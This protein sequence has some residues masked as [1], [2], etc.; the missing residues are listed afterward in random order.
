M[1]KLFTFLMTMVIAMVAANAADIK[2]TAVIGEEATSI[3]ALEGKT[4]AIINKAEGKALYG[5]NAQNLAYDVY[6]NAFVNT[7]SGYKWKLVSLADDAD[8]SVRSYYRIQLVTPTGADYNCWGMGGVLNSQPAGQDVSFILGIS[9]KNGQDIKNGAVYDVQYVEGEG[10]S[11]KNI[12]TG[13]YQGANTLPAKAA[14]PTYFSFVEEVSFNYIAAVKELLAEGEA[15]KANVA[16]EEAKE[17]YDAAIA[18]IDPDAL[19]GD[20]L[21]EAQAI[22]AAIIALAKHQNAGADLTR[23][24]ANP[25]FEAGNTDGWVNNGFAIAP[26]TDFPL[27]AGVKYAEKWTQA[28]G[29]VGDAKITQEITGLPNGIYE[30]SAAMRLIAQNEGD[31][32]KAGLFL[33]ANDEKVAV[34]AT[35]VIKA[36]IEVTDGVLVIGAEI[37]DAQGNWANIDNF[38]LT[39]EGAPATEEEMAPIVAEKAIAEALGVDVSAY[40]NQ[41]IAAAAVESVVNALKVAEYKQVNADYTQNAASLIPDFAEWEGGMVSNKGQHWDG[42]ATSTYY[43]QTGAQWGQSSW[44]NNKKTTVNLPKGKY[45][46]YAAGRASA[47]TDCIAYIKVNDE[48]RVF[49]SKGDVGFGIATDGVA[50]FDPATAAFANGNIGRGFEYRYIAFEVT[51][52]EGEDIALEIGGKATAAH[53]WMSVT[54]PILLTTADNATITKQVLAADIAIAQ[55]VVDAKAGVGDDLFMI[56]TEAFDTFEAAVNAAKDVNDNA[57]A[58]TEDIN[59]AIADLAAATEAYNSTPV[60]TPDPK[61]LYTFQL[62]LDAETPLYMNLSEGVK[63]QEEATPLSFVAAA[64]AGQYYLDARG[65]LS[66]GRDGGNTW[67]MSTAAEKRIAWGFTALGNGEYHI[68]NLV[69]AGRFVGTNSNETTANTSCYCDKQTSNGNVVWIIEEYIAPA[70][71]LN[72]P[73][74]NVEEGTQAE[75]TMLAIDETLKITYTADN[76]EANEVPADDVKVKITVVV[77]GDLPE[78]NLVGSATAHRV[79]GETF[80]IPLGETDFPVALKEGY[81]YQNIAVMA[82]ELVKPA[83]ND[84]KEQT[85]ATYVGAPVQL[86]WVGVASKNTSEI[87]ISVE[88]IVNQGYTAQTESCDFTEAAEFLGVDAI[89][90]D[91]LRV[92][93]AGGTLSS[94]I[95]RYDGWFNKDGY[96]ETWGENAFVCVKLFQAIEDGEYEICDMNNPQVG[97]E[98]TAKWAAVNGT[99]TVYFNINV[100]FIEKPVIALTFDDLNQVGDEVVVPFTSECGEYYEEM[101]GNV[102]VA[103]ILNTL[104]AE[105]ISDVDIYAVQSDGSLDNSYKLGTTDGWRNA[106]GDWQSWGAEARFCVKVN[107]AADEDQIYYVGGMDG[108][109]AEP[110]E[111]TATFAFVKKASEAHDAVVLKVTLTYDYNV[112]ID[113][114]DAAKAK[115]NG[116]YLQN[117]K[118]VIVNNG[119]TYSVSGVEIK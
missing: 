12:G 73:T 85:L 99:K 50:A 90:E 91:M 68:N 34:E 48:E 38:T 43:E 39:F 89:T 78:N 113:G 20:G 114:I 31:A 110:A 82:A 24:I 9:D 117:G 86:H 65:E 17:A 37:S 108:Q 62:K 88:R 1:K 101:T 103:S 81:V 94:E 54:S 23:V 41:P 96:A 19:E 116:K 61:K 30:V 6:A 75:P 14:E 21:A 80:Y 105:S 28:P 42:T 26:N 13:F 79:L 5:S 3:A 56:P 69:T 4:F 55:A 49:P 52:D 2:P 63:I 59:A 74:F 11:L 100:K 95:E 109:N 106:D 104:G 7:N 107:F 40:G 36:T 25:S 35:G 115:G 33:L 45:V 72:A 29:P 87:A 77:S 18:D 118:I 46:L 16:D 44:E 47:D 27:I 32:D 98:V 70:I 71:V 83:T 57:E 97:D 84:T 22:D 58:T 64:N 92:V 67:T 66:V 76:L 10:F 51:A 102:D 111:Y 60:N 8:E 15:I 119:K 93:E 53:Q 112:S